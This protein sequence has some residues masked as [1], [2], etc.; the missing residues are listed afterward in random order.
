M[1][2][3]CPFVIK[4]CSRCHRILVANEMN[5][6]KHKRGK[7]GLHAECKQCRKKYR[8]SDKGKKAQKKADKK[9]YEN[10]P[11]KI[12]NKSN[13]RRQLEGQQGNG[14]TKEQYFE[15][16]EFF[17]WRCAYSG[18][19]IGNNTNP[20]RT[21]DHILP[22][23]KGGLNEVWNCIPMHKS[24]NSSK[25]DKDMLEWYKEQEFYSEERLAKI[26]AW[27]EYAYNKW[28]DDETM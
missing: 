19:Y 15:M 17:K 10:N 24:Y 27:C 14:L 28:R 21:V 25:Q 3:K 16:M 5:F 22:L 23:N 6:Y 9:Y 13:K 12:F 11:H 1:L 18:E 4:V 7:W 26:Y 8:Q 20:N 2:M